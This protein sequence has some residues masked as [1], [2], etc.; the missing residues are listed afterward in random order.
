VNL[1]GRDGQIPLHTA[2]RYNTV[3]LTQD[4]QNAISYL[5]IQHADLLQRDDHG[6]SYRKMFN[7][8]CFCLRSNSASSRSNAK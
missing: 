7:D 3:C 1:I 5:I 6:K 2:A 4:T 8:S